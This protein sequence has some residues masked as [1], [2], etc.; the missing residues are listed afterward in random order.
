MNVCALFLSSVNILLFKVTNFLNSLVCSSCHRC[1]HVWRR[2]KFQCF[3]IYR[4]EYISRGLQS[5][6]IVGVVLLWWFCHQDFGKI[7]AHNSNIILKF[8][9]Q[10]GLHVGGAGSFTGQR[11]HHLAARRDS[12]T[13]RRTGT[14]YS[15]ACWGPVACRRTGIVQ[16]VETQQLVKLTDTVRLESIWFKIFLDTCTLRY[17]NQEV[18]MLV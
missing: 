6:C 10:T 13:R 16:H 1:H 5:A 17:R 8:Q 14:W 2:R 3:W 4:A 15:T 11:A 7:D 12:A 9:F 18:N